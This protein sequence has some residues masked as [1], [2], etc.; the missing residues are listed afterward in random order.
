MHKE[1]LIDKEFANWTNYK[2]YLDPYNDYKGS[3]R[4]GNYINTLMKS[5]KNKLDFLLP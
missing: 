1:K 3:E 4:V 2:D 5:L